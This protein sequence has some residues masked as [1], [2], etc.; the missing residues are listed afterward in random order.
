MAAQTLTAFDAVLKDVYGPRVEEQLNQTNPLA[1]F[2]DENDSADWTGRQVTYPIHV[3]RNQGVGASAE[4]DPLPAAGKQ[5]YATVKIPER[6]N[7]GRVSLTAQVIKASLKSEGAFERAMESELKGLVKD[8]GNERERQVFGYG[9]GILA[10]VAST[11]TN[12]LFVDS[13]MN[14]AGTVNGARFLERG[15]QSGARRDGHKPVR[16]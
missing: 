4:G 8:L 2:I 12:T 13:P 9:S 11:S 5:G 10:L 16:R 15:A 14:V 6:F 1:D 7:Y 3:S